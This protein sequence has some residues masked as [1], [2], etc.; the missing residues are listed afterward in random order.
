[1][2]A[3]LREMGFTLKLKMQILSIVG[4]PLTCI[5]LT[6]NEKT[7]CFVVA[8]IVETIVFAQDNYDCFVSM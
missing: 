7:L 6:T 5:V 4:E 1:M 8:G 3:V 2:G